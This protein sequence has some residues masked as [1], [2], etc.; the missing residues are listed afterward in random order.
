MK[1][2][3]PADISLRYKIPLRVIALVLATAV[4]VTASMVFREYDESRRDLVAH[5]AGLGRVLA[6]TL[7]TPL[8][9]DDLW[10]AY[11]VIRSP[12]R[13]S[14]GEFETL[15][16]EIVV[17]LDPGFHTFVSTQPTR[18]PLNINPAQLEGDFSKIQAALEADDVGIQRLIELPA[19]GY[20]YMVTPI[21]A[22]GVLL[23][24][25]VLGYSR[26]VFIPRLGNLV[27]RS[28]LVTL[29]V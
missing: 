28:A 5:A 19:S 16:T 24:R 26:Q 9:H 20:I 23:G 2:I 4:I 29:L 10:R 11:E 14:G 7:T 15:A 25:L 22:D 8:I 1:L 6:D 12:Q 18:F 21:I 17:V 3:R 27:T 13:R